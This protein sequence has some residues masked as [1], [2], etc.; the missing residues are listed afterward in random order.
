[1]L[2]WRKLNAQKHLNAYLKLMSP[3]SSLNRG[4]KKN[5]MYSIAYLSSFLQL[6]KSLAA[7]TSDQQKDI[8]HLYDIHFGP[9]IGGE[10][11]TPPG[12]SAIS[13]QERMPSIDVRHP[14]ENGFCMGLALA[15]SGVFYESPNLDYAGVRQTYNATFHDVPIGIQ[16]EGLL[17]PVHAWVARL[18]YRFAYHESP[19]V[20]GTSMTSGLS[21]TKDAVFL[22]TLEP[23]TGDRHALLFGRRGDSFFIWDSNRKEE[24]LVSFCFDKAED[25][26]AKLAQYLVTYYP[27]FQ[28]KFVEKIDMDGAMLRDIQAEKHAPLKGRAPP[29]LAQAGS[30]GPNPDLAPGL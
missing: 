6:Q 12:F 24:D 23:N 22:L 5:V 15:F 11:R 4:E 21:D 19:K 30:P 16:A 17:M 13:V 2:N 9:E 20:E 8:K 1:M 28:R 25:F 3:E 14:L 26:D 7:L 10:R 29:K 18:H 27:T